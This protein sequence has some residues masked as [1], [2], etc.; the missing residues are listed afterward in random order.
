MSAFSRPS[1]RALALSTI[2]ALGTPAFAADA[3]AAKPDAP[4]LAPGPNVGTAKPLGDKPADVPLQPVFNGKDLTGW[5]PKDATLW[6]VKD[7]VLVGES[8]D[9][10][11]KGDTMRLAAPT[12]ANFA[13]EADVR[14]PDNIDSGVMWGKPETQVQF[15]VSRSLKTDMSACLYYGGK[16]PE[17]AR[18]KVAGILKLGEWNH[19]R[20]EHKDGNVK[21]WLNGQHVLNWDAPKPSD[22][23]P[24]GIQ[25]HG[26]VVM[27]VEFKNVKL[28]ELK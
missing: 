3:P 8:T 2:L 12:P 19:W 13:F 18:A 10:K 16:Y 20:I 22:P 27:K 17:P 5:T 26:G 28:G 15:G 21:V 7:G 23:A 1:I 6:S 4:A 14:Y 11:T 9:P 25:I 24:I